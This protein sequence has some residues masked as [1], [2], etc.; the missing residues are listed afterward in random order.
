MIKLKISYENEQEL[1][2]L[3]QKLDGYVYDFRR[4]GNCS[5]HYRKAYLY[6]TGDPRELRRLYSNDSEPLRDL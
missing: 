6:F 4:S 3:L 5:G 1:K 2:T